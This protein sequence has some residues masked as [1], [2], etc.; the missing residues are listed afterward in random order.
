MNLISL[1]LTSFL[2]LSCG[3]YSFSGASI[4][5]HIKSCQVLQ[6]DNLS[7]RYD[8]LL[9]Q[10]LTDLLIEK[11]ESYDLLTIENDKNSNSKIIGTIKS[12]TD[13]VRSKIDDDTVDKREIK[14]VITIQ[15]FDNI[16]NKPIVKQRSLSKVKE[17]DEADGDEGFNKVLEEIL[18]EISDAAALALI[19]NW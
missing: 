14:I 6:F 11:I 13:N 15:L 2:F 17:Y 18:E 10:K 19:S 1:L 9:S 16:N 4:P 8:L 5:P 7:S 12:F 3:Y